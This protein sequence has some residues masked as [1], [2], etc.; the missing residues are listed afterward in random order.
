MRSKGF[1]A[2]FVPGDAMFSREREVFVR[3]TASLT[4]PAVYG[5]RLFP[6]A[7]GLMSFS[8]DLVE[9]CRRAA[10]HVYKIARGTRA[11]DLPVEE[12]VKF[13]VVINVAAA[14][15]LGLNIPPALRER[16][17]LVGK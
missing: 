4:L 7:G 2:L 1:D 3:R 15:A 5:D 14:S 11:G 13:D 10:G 8:V 6:D 16:A 17:E 12:A 9:L